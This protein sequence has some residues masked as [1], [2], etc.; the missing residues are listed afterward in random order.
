MQSFSIH[1]QLHH[2]LLQFYHRVSVVRLD[3]QRHGDVALG[4][5]AGLVDGSKRDRMSGDA[6]KR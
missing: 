2:L 3:F 5:Q 4:G 6:E 1:Q